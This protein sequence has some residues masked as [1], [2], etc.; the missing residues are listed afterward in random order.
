MDNLIDRALAIASIVHEG[1]IDKSGKP[2]ILHI[3]NVAMQ[4]TNDIEIVTGLLHDVV[5]DSYGVVTIDTL[6]ENNFPQEVVVAVDHLTR[7]STETYKEYLRRC[8]KDPLAARVKFYDLQHNL[9]PSRDNFAGAQS[10]RE[11]H[12]WAREYVI[13]SLQRKGDID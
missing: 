11:R 8:V 10:L 4:G 6:I 5:E 13:R 1:Q 12:L 2:F 9:D 3:L 7:R